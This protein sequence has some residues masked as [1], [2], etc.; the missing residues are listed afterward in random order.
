LRQPFRLLAWL[1]VATVGA[2]AGIAGVLV[3]DGESRDVGTGNGAPEASGEQTVKVVR[4]DITVVTAVD[5]VTAPLPIFRILA[6]RNGTVRYAPGVGRDSDMKQGATLFRMGS[7]EVRA[8][9]AARFEQWLVPDGGVAWSGVPVMELR[10][11]GFGLLGSLPATDAYRLLSGDLSATGSIAGGP[12]GFDC[13]VLE[14]PSVKPDPQAVSKASPT[15]ICAIPEDV[16]AYADLQGQIALSSGQVS[17]VL[18][19]PVTAVSGGADRGEVSIVSDDGSVTIRQVGLGA[20]NGAIVEI[21]TGLEEG[22]RVL[23]SPPPL[24]R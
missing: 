7:A 6:P 22:M 10:Y 19:L 13:P 9:V 2:G 24:V 4:Q 21:T 16:R 8:P 1:L 3:V 23:A 18:T 17:Q 11:I 14:V 5:A 12:A 15:V 20:T